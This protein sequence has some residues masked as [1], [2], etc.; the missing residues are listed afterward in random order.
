MKLLA[1]VIVIAAAQSGDS[2]P[3]VARQRAIATE[4]VAET[5]A[6]E[7]APAADTATAEDEYEYYYT[8]EEEGLARSRGGKTKKKRK[9]GSAAAAAAPQRVQNNAVFVRPKPTVFV[10]PKKPAKQPPVSFGSKSGDYYD[11]GVANSGANRGSFNVY[12]YAAPA[13]TQ[14]PVNLFHGLEY[15]DYLDKF[16]IEVGA[17][18]KI[19]LTLP[20]DN[21]TRAWAFFHRMWGHAQD[22]RRTFKN[23]VANSRVH[24]FVGHPR[25][26][27]DVSNNLVD[28]RYSPFSEVTSSDDGRHG[29]TFFEAQGAVAPKFQPWKALDDNQ[30]VDSTA[31]WGYDGDWGALVTPAHINFGLWDSSWELGAPATSNAQVANRWFQGIHDTRNGAANQD[32]DTA[33]LTCWHC[34]V[35]YGLTWHPTEREFQLVTAGYTG[36][37]AWKD[38]E[39][40]ANGHARFC[41]YSSGVCFVEERRTFGFTT[42]VRKGCKQAQACYRNK[43]Q[44]FLVQAGRQC[45]PGDARGTLSYVPRRPND[46]MADQ[47]IYN[48]VA[49]GKAANA[50][51]GLTTADGNNNGADTEARAIIDI[52]AAFDQT[53]TDVDSDGLAGG[54]GTTTGFYIDPR[55]LHAETL[56]NQ[57]VKPKEPMAYKNGYM[58]T[59]WCYQCCNSGTQCNKEWRPETERD[60]SRNWIAG[61]SG[62]SND[63]E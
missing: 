62:P 50:G 32:A 31:T 57:F 52:D 39:E 49:G 48:L 34:E 51:H 24:H 5:A 2:E 9:K 22:E 10:R 42:L 8:Y 21:E 3:Q 6:A 20:D 46:V 61:G 11:Y 55:H 14:A 25:S 41:E 36:G 12:D 56:A 43:H 16:D 47:W 53:F 40:A 30:A 28:S 63:T 13:P 54:A 4:A 44:N 18:G 38:C 37:G 27:W 26:G 29:K 15:D 1:G 23:T 45:W 7:E 33:R 35:Q 59:S 60:W 17:N 58:F 19:G